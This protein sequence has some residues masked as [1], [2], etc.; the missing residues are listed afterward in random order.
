[1]KRA[2][3]PEPRD[4]PPIGEILETLESALLSFKDAKKGTSRR[5]AEAAAADLRSSALLTQASKAEEEDA[6]KAV[7]D[8]KA[9]TKSLEEARALRIVEIK[10]RHNDMAAK[11]RIDLELEEKRLDEEARREMALEMEKNEIMLA[12]RKAKWVEEVNEKKEERLRN[13][14]MLDE[15]DRARIVAE[16][17]LENREVEKRV[18]ASR[19]EQ[20]TKLEAR[21]KERRDAKTRAAQKALLKLDQESIE[22]VENEEKKNIH[23]FL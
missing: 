5:A 2:W 18:E 14:H 6:K 12:Q 17:E 9:L 11:M 22:A 16:F 3:D 23:D 8:L 19:I 10:K 15:K 1:M 20:T 13:S 4:R 7:E 21:L